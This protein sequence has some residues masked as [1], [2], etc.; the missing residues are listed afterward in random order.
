MRGSIMDR[1][2]VINETKTIDYAQDMTRLS[3]SDSEVW[4]IKYF[5]IDTEWHFH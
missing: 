4:S 1:L 3:P 5:I 2:I